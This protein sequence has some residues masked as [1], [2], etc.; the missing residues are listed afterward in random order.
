MSSLIWPCFK[1][2]VTHPGQLEPFP[3]NCHA[4]FRRRPFFCGQSYTGES[5]KATWRPFSST[6]WEPGL[7]WK[8]S[9]TQGAVSEAERK[10]ECIWDPVSSRMWAGSVPAFSPF[11]L[12]YCLE[13]FHH[14][15]TH[16]LNLVQIMI[17]SLVPDRMIDQV[18]AINPIFKWENS[19]SE[20]VPE[21]EAYLESLGEWK[22][23]WDLNLG[24][25]EPKAK[26]FPLAHAVSCGPCQ[27]S[28]RNTFVSFCISR[29]L[30]GRQ[31][32]RHNFFRGNLI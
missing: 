28:G 29:N 30:A 9:S 4:G 7:W 11:A 26:P 6:I 17:L 5:L 16:L 27:A 15:F 12:D 13:T 1:A 3:G 22:Q 31:K 19:G 10:P 23:S 32:S 8:I 14:S 18:C 21:A 2:T 24:P 20:K 25:P